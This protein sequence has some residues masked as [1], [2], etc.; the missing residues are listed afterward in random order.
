MPVRF[1]HDRQRPSIYF[2]TFTCYKWKRLFEL[3]GAYDSVY[4]WFDSLYKKNARVISYVIMPNHV[5]ALLY[6]PEMWASLNS[7]IGNVKRFMAYDIISR[8]EENKEIQLL[9]ELYGFVTKNERN[10]GQRHKVFEDSFDAKECRTR[11]FIMQKLDYI[12]KNPVSKRWQLVREY[13]EYEHSS[14]AYYER[15]IMRYNKLLHAG[16]IL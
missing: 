12:H 9:E 3:P 2:I 10:K 15:A 11:K 16:E 14:A 8:L 1:Q 13:T 4:K 6:F 7:I 5:H